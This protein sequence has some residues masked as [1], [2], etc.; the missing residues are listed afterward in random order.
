MLPNQNDRARSLDL[1]SLS[2]GFS[3]IKLTGQINRNSLTSGVLLMIRHDQKTVHPTGPDG[4]CT[5]THAMAG[6]I[7]VDTAANSLQAA[8]S[9]LECAFVEQKFYFHVTPHM[10]LG[11]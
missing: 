4:H 1:L 10:A 9:Q 7:F 5:G 2:M 11:P 8:D 6:Q 3:F